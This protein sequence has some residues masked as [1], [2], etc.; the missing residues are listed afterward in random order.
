MML[1]LLLS[2]QLDE[3]TRNYGINLYQENKFIPIV[4]SQNSEHQLSL[5]KCSKESIKCS[6][7]HKY[8]ISLEIQRAVGECSICQRIINY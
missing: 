2:L 3:N 4:S 1:S 7:V 8:L 5:F 6:S